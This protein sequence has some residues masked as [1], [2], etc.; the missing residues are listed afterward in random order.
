MTSTTLTLLAPVSLGRS[1]AHAAS[2]PHATH[3]SHETHAEPVRPSDVQRTG[4]SGHT[5]S[6]VVTP[7]DDATARTGPPTSSV[8]LREPRA[9]SA[10]SA[11]SAGRPG[12]PGS[13]GSAGG[14]GGAGGESRAGRAG[15]AGCAGRESQRRAAGQREGAGLRR[16]WSTVVEHGTDAGMATAE[17]A[18]AMIA[19]VGFAGLLVTVLS[20]ATVRGLLTGL[21]T[22][23][24][25]IG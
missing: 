14:A 12:R 5:G 13:A 6:E 11:G 19:A 22:S 9:G 16:R 2:G 18:I 1:D 17:Y 7:R 3:E 8:S 20:S 24:L 25:S 4:C 23:A 10:G 21:V 15:G